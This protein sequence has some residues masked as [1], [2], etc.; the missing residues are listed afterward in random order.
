MVNDSPIVVTQLNTYDNTGKPEFP[1]QL[2]KINVLVLD[3]HDIYL[4]GFVL[5]LKL[6]GFNVIGFTNKEADFKKLLIRNRSIADI[7][8]VNYKLSKRET[9]EVARFVK[10]KYPRI[11]VVINTQYAGGLLNKKLQAIGIEGVI[12]KTDYNTEQ[13]IKALLSVYQG[14]TLW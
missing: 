6:C 2:D 1:T 11:R 7:A 3:Y 4:T 14:K 13:I 10:E 12:L 9:L 5:Y 8:I